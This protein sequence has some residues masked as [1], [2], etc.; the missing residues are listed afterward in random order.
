MSQLAVDIFRFHLFIQEELNKQVPTIN[1]GNIH[2]IHCNCKR[3][4]VL[5]LRKFREKNVYTRAYKYILYILFLSS[6]KC[7]NCANNIGTVKTRSGIG[8]RCRVKTYFVK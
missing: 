6:N 7:T 5:T 3:L 2:T 1:I 8:T 4:S